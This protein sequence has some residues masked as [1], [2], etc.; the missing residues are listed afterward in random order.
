MAIV[1]GCDP[2]ASRHCAISAQLF[3]ETYLKGKIGVSRYCRIRV[4]F[5]SS[6]V[7][8]LFRSRRREPETEWKLSGGR[9]RK[10]ALRLIKLRLI[11]SRRNFAQEPMAD[12]GR[13]GWGWAGKKIMLLVVSSNIDLPSC[14]NTIADRANPLV[15]ERIPLPLRVGCFQDVEP[16]LRRKVGS[17]HG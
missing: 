16:L 17:H 5:G 9:E 11:K 7:R 1:T 14:K 2:T 15:I 10:F 4:G 3:A 12:I 8:T 6:S 13:A